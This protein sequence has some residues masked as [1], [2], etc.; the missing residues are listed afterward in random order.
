[1]ILKIVYN[2]KIKEFFIKFNLNEINEI[3]KFLFRRRH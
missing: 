2:N 3:E 1:M